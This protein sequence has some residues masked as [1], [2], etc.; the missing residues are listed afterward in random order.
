MLQNRVIG[1]EICFHAKEV[2]NVLELFHTRYTLFKQCYI[3]RAAKAIE[4]MITDALIEADIAWDGK[5]SCAIDDPAEYCKLTDHIL[6]QIEVS[7]DPSLDKAQ[8]IIKEFRKRN[9]YK[10]VDEYLMDGETAQKL[11]KV[12]SADISSCNCTD[13]VQLRPEDIIVHD[14]KLNY[15]NKDQSPL[16]NTLFFN[17]Y[18]NP[19]SFHVASN[20]VSYILPVNF[21]ER[22]LRIY[23]R[24]RDNETIDAIQKA[25]RKFLKSF[26]PSTSSSPA[27]CAKSPEAHRQYAQL[28]RDAGSKS[29]KE[30]QFDDGETASEN[31]KKRR[32]RQGQLSFGSSQ[33]GS[34]DDSGHEQALKLPPGSSY[35]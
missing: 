14:H 13:S 15:G 8:N 30:L 21:Q 23:S 34:Q 29:R 17:D 4:Y 27:P 2:Y 26:R 7:E 10:F 1:G 3:H 5:I 16:D 33:N 19:E 22:I 32:L 11:R 18:N 9:L 6:K 25:F 35:M 31:R 12:T 20:K 24:K 28:R